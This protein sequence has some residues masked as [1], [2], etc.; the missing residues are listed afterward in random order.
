MANTR[1]Y[2]EGEQ[3][4]LDCPAGQK[5]TITKSKIENEKGLSEE[6]PFPGGGAA[7]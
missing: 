4:A 5:S 6:R 7:D 1:F 2:M 3:P